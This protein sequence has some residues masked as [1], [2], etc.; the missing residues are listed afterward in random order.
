MSRFRSVRY[1]LYPSRAQSRRMGSFLELCRSAYNSEVEM[2][3]A[4]YE[5]DGSF[6]D[7][8]SIEEYCEYVLKLEDP[9]L[10]EVF[11]ECLSDVSNRVYRLF[12]RFIL[13][14]GAGKDSIVLPTSKGPERY[15]SFSY[16]RFKG[17]VRLKADGRIW[18]HGI[19]Y[20]RCVIHRPI[21]GAPFSCTVSRTAVGKWYA[22]ISFI[23]NQTLEPIVDAKDRRPVGVDLGLFNLA[24]FSD[25]TVYDNKKLFDRMAAEMGKIQRKMSLFDVGTEEHERYKRRLAHLFEHYNN[26]V[27]DEM[28]KRS[29]EVVETYSM[30]ALEAID[31]KEMIGHYHTHAGRRSQSTAAWRTFVE[32]I[33]YKAETCGV[34]VVFVDPRFTSQICSGCGAFVSKGLGVRVHVCPMCGLVLD[35]DVNAARNILRIGLGMQASVT[36]NRNRRVS[37]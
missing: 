37:I 18:L 19:G 24:V 13:L 32:M 20:V 5:L 10:E 14:R 26:R 23:Q 17:N 4:A 30:V 36:G 16:P 34:E 11:P 25:G 1:R 8:D 12:K 9:L 22:T 15:R 35:R 31:V 6:L 28:H 33:E 3:R 29:T 27:K 2:C 21:E 7:R